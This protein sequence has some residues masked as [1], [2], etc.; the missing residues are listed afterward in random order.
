MGAE[1]GRMGVQWRLGGVPVPRVAD[2]KQLSL[3][4]RS[5]DGLE[6]ILRLGLED[7]GC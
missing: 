4:W 2:C 3:G 1:P 5:I 6:C 7:D